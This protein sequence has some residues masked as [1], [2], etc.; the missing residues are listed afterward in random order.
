MLCGYDEEHAHTDD[1]YITERVL[2]CALLEGWSYAE[3]EEDEPKADEIAVET[4]VDEPDVIEVETEPETETESET[5]LPEP[6][7][8][9]EIELHEHD[10]TCYDLDRV[11]CG[12]LGLTFHQHTDDCEGICYTVEK[13]P[14][15]AKELTCTPEETPGHTHTALCYGTWE[16]ICGKEE[17]T[18]TE[19]CRQETAEATYEI[20]LTGEEVSP[21]VLGTG[22][23]YDVNGNLIE[24]EWYKNS[25][26]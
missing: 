21:P 23:R 17:H 10:V 15:D 2:V 14:L 4:A 26:L 9:P 22:H 3:T 1:C 18:H 19:V 25:R 12:K 5:E 24:I 6:C 16:L 11:I 20:A 13:I 7:D 8:K